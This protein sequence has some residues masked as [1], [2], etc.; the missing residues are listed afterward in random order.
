MKHPFFSIEQK[1]FKEETMLDSAN[2][3]LI[4]F[5]VT[6]F[7]IFNKYSS[8]SS[9]RREFYL[10][11]DPTITV[12]LGVKV[13][14]LDI[15]VTAKFVFDIDWRWTQAATY[16]YGDMS[17]YMNYTI[18]VASFSVYSN[19]IGSKDRLVKQKIF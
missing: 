18:K 8:G 6:S 9:V 12:Y 7:G 19:S 17:V 13:K 3:Y 10:F 15:N 4:P 14:I 1:V 5:D 11:I 16:A 2:E